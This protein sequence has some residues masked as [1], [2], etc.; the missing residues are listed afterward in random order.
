[1]DK[2]GTLQLKSSKKGIFKAFFATIVEKAKPSTAELLG[3]A[4]VVLCLN[5]RPADFLL[6]VCPCSMLHAHVVSHIGIPSSVGHRNLFINTDVFI[7]ECCETAP[8]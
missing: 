7:P 5:Y 8:Q 2:G 6:Q 3:L 4:A 1:M